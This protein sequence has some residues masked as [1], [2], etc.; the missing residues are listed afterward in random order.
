MKVI[1][2]ENEYVWWKFYCFSSS[3]RESI[4]LLFD[5]CF[6]EVHRKSCKIVKIAQKDS[7]KISIYHNWLFSISKLYVADSQSIYVCL[8]SKVTTPNTLMLIV[9][10]CE[11][12]TLSSRL[13]GNYCDFGD[14]L[15]FVGRFDAV[16]LKW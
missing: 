13:L 8:L 3:K 7:W 10:R 1:D 5:I 2:D 14:V 15:C 4:Q 16:H 11:D 9:A 6:S 12:H